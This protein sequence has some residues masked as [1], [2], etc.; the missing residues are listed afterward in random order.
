L[1]DLERLIANADYMREMIKSPGGKMVVKYI[2]DQ[3][4]AIKTTL[5]RADIGE[6][7]Q[8]QGKARAYQT[9]LNYI[10]DTILLGEQAIKKIQGKQS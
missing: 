3:I 5:L 4:E 1:D 9:V 10:D 2:R 8:L 7:P 6:I